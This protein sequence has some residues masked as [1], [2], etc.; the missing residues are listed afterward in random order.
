MLLKTFNSSDSILYRVLKLDLNSSRRL[1]SFKYNVNWLKLKPWAPEWTSPGKDVSLCLFCFYF[2]IV[3]FNF[4][5]WIWNPHST[6]LKVS[7]LY[8]TCLCEAKA[9]PDVKFL[10]NS[11]SEHTSLKW[12][13]AWLRHISFLIYLFNKLNN[14]L[15]HAFSHALLFKH[16]MSCSRF[17]PRLTWKRQ[18]KPVYEL[19][20]DATTHFFSL[21]TSL[22]SSHLPVTHDGWVGHDIKV[23]TD[24]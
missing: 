24:F 9:Q 11:H 5:S 19:H 13:Q 23:K 17:T 2:F 1:W 4:T 20:F 16:L 15:M 3:A 10:T 8:F 6:A 14:N 12:Q 22:T 21:Q 18:I 7:G